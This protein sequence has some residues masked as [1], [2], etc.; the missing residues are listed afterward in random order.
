MNMNIHCLTS[1]MLPEKS[2]SGSDIY[3]DLY[4]H[5]K[6]ITLNYKKESHQ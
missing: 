5:I 2:V 3:L 1:N 4:M 6:P